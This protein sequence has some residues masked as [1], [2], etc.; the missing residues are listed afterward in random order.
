M[1]KALLFS[2]GSR[3]R[4]R[5][6]PLASF[7][8]SAFQIPPPELDATFQRSDTETAPGVYGIRREEAL[9]V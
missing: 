7:T 2:K 1:Q 4:Y 8:F 5:Y 6:D 3:F 9:T